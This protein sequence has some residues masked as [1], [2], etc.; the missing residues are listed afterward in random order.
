MLYGTPL[1]LLGEFFNQGEYTDPGTFMNKF[2][3]QIKKIKLVPTAHHARKKVFVHKTLYE[4]T[5]VFVRVDA[6]KKPLEPPY[7]GPF[8]VLD[9]TSDDVFRIEY[10][11]KP[12]MISV[13]WLKP[14]R[15]ETNFESKNAEPKTY[16][17]KKT[18]RFAV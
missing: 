17:R 13:E 15:V 6:A 4:C 18:V 16:I 9:R 3:Q 5:H 11:G 2:R 14:A 10:K 12:T 8:L 7:E 1:R